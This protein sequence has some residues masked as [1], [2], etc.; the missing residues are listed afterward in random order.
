MITDQIRN[1]KLANHHGS[2][3]EAKINFVDIAWVNN[4]AH[5]EDDRDMYGNRNEDY[6]NDKGLNH[7]GEA[8]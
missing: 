5:D 8:R 4:G 7:S 6:N 3:E 2:D 1:V